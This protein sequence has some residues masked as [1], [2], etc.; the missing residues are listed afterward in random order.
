MNHHFPKSDGIY[1]LDTFHVINKSNS[2]VRMKA[3]LPVKFPEPY[4]TCYKGNRRF[5]CNIERSAYHS[6]IGFDTGDCLDKRLVS[7]DPGAGTA[8]REDGNRV[9][10]LK[11][12]TFRCQQ[13]GN[14]KT[15]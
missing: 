1:V 7:S 2:R 10:M 12:L 9:K 8:G 14:L 4:L 11:H 13:Q 5:I 6:L 3:S 15:G